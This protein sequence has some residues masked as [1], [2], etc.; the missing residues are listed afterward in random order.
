MAEDVSALPLSDLTVDAETRPPLPDMGD[1]TEAQLQAGRHLAAIHRHYL[2]DL[3]QIAKVMTRIE[4]GDAPSADLAHIV[5]HSQMAQNFAAAG[6][7]CGQQCWALTMHHN[8]EE[9]SIFPQLHARGSEPVR[10]IVDRLRAE[11][12]VVHALLERLGAA[13]GGLSEAPSSEQFAETRAIFDQ[14]VAV[15]RSH[16]KFEESALAEALG[17]YHVDI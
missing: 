12:E 13:A 3:S 6:T 4:A 2:S 14:L 5:L 10:A 16:F 9:Q 8:I 15:V 7:L 1:V 11:H 17:V